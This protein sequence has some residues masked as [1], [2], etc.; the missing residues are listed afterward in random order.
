MRNSKGALERFNEALDPAPSDLAT[1]PLRA[2]GE[3]WKVSGWHFR[4]YGEVQRFMSSLL[5]RFAS[6]APVVKASWQVPNTATKDTP[7]GHSLDGLNST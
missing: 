2:L 5:G 1:P 7:R 3:D 6:G 4:E